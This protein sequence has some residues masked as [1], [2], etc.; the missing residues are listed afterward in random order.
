[1][2]WETQERPAHI[3][4]LLQ[5]KQVFT[6]GTAVGII[7]VQKIY[8]QGQDYQFDTDLKTLQMVYNQARDGEVALPSGWRLHIDDAKQLNQWA[9]A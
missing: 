9:F 5:A 8:Y 1:M 4:E 3:E 6:M 7:P 2:S